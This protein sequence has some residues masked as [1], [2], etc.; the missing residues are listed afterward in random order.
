M[1]ANVVVVH[2]CHCHTLFALS[3]SSHVTPFSLHSHV[4]C[5]EKLSL[6]GSIGSRLMRPSFCG[7]SRRNEESEFPNI[8]CMDLKTTD[9]GI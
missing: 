8:I 1:S 7:G 6:S 2:P 4:W 5:L 9:L 3:C